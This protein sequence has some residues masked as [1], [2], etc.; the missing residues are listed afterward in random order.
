MIQVASRCCHNI[1]QNIHQNNSIRK[2]ITKKQH[3][4]SLT[5]T[6]QLFYKQNTFPT[7]IL[8]TIGS[9]PNKET[10]KYINLEQIIEIF[11]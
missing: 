2:I 11:E 10:Y 3:I 9:D 4:T 7:E 1:L 5:N 8:F 6:F